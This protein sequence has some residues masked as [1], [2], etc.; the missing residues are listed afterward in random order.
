MCMWMCVLVHVSISLCRRHKLT[1]N[2]FNKHCTTGAHPRGTD[3]PTRYATEILP[4]KKQ[5]EVH[6]I[7]RS[8]IRAP[9]KKKKTCCRGSITAGN[10][11]AS[12]AGGYG[13]GAAGTG[14]TGGSDSDEDEEAEAPPTPL[15]DRK[16]KVR[17]ERA[18][19][20]EMLGEGKGD[21]E[22][23][24][25]TIVYIRRVFTSANIYGNEV[26]METGKGGR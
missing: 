5:F 7:H 4:T 25:Q 10:G 18:P 11:A 16:L 17:P 24:E 3:P 22:G 15:E 23:Q 14:I 8:N 21:G 1:K 12:A 9:R 13:G 26:Y 20:G 2:R 6:F 19:E